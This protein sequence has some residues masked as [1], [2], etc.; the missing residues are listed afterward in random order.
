[1]LIPNDSSDSDS[2]DEPD[3]HEKALRARQ[4]L[5]LRQLQAVFH[6]GRQL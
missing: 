3:E 2:D 1:M 5:P 6:M 4:G